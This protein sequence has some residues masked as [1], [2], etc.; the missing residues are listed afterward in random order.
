MVEN[1]IYNTETFSLEKSQDKKGYILKGNAMPL[2]ETSRNGV[3]YRPESVKKAY[4]SL[5]GNS[6]LFS[7][8]QDQVNHVLGHVTKSG[9]S[10]SHVTYEVD[11][12]PE[13]KDFIRKSERGD[14][15]HVSVGAII[16]PETVEIDEDKGI[17][18]VDVEEFAELSSAPVPGYKNTSAKLNT[19]MAIAEKFGNEDQV[20]KLK[21]KTQETEDEKPSEEEPEDS[22]DTED[23]PEKDEDEKELEE[24]KKDTEEPEKLDTEDTEDSEDTEDTKEPEESEVNESYQEDKE[25]SEADKEDNEEDKSEEDM[26]KE[27]FAGYKNFDD[28]VKKNQDKK[29]PKAY[30]GKIQKKAKDKDNKTQN[31]S[32]ETEDESEEQTVEEQ[33]SELKTL[34]DEISGKYEEIQNRLS[35]LESKIDQLLDEPEEEKSK[36]Q[37]T[38]KLK[39]VYN[40]DKFQEKSDPTPNI[41]PEK[42]QERKEKELGLDKNTDGKKLDSIDLNKIIRKNRRY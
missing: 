42:Y 28:C 26:S 4:K 5:E 3:Y 20:K 36:E 35:A 6:F 19:V 18:Y 17:A 10:D 22:K 16:N 34:Y 14:I 13:E 30:C 21:Q 23:N 9:L 38:Q 40:E 31:T 29:D 24:D 2:G 25:E 27:P 32:N 15:K 11:I 41:K 1:K 7:H 33:V 8:Q 37:D 39:E 12:D